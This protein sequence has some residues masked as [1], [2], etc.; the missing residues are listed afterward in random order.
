[1]CRVPQFYP[2]NNS[3]PLA[4]PR[5]TI[6]TFRSSTKI[7][8]MAGS[9]FGN[10]LMPDSVVLFAYTESAEYGIEYVLGRDLSGDFRE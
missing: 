4:R 2:K 7:K 8:R 5:R 10:V 1:M 3:Y 6:H 9:I